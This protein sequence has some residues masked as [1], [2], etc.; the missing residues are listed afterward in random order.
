MQ[1]GSS[2]TRCTDSAM[3]QSTAMLWA[4]ER[5]FTP[6]DKV[7]LTPLT[8]RRRPLVDGSARSEPVRRSEG[9]GLGAHGCASES[10]HRQ[11][12]G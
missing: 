8:S 7:G 11:D 1:I 4:P 5:T 10:Y 9:A 2:R 3:T 12:T 6:G